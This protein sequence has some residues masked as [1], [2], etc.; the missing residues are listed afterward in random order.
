[1]S[2]QAQI[3]EAGRRRRAWLAPLLLLALL[4]VALYAPV[5]RGLVRQWWQEPDYGH[6]FFVPLFAGYVLWRERV[7]LQ[8]LALE[9]ANSGLL[10]MLAAV[11][12]LLAGSLGAELFVSRFS[13]L[14]LLAGMTLYLAGRKMLRAVAFPLGFLVLMIPLPA[15]LYYQLT[16]PLQLLASRA[17]EASLDLLRV[18]VVREGNLLFL[19]NYTL[20]VVEACSGVRSLLSLAALAIGYGYLLESRVWARL[21]LLLFVVPIA[22]LTNA[23]RVVATGLLTHFYGPQAADSFLHLFSGWL[24]FVVAL[25]L[26]LLVH[27]VLRRFR[28]PG[29]ETAHA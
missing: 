29:G 21:A 20:E 9:P 5:L 17:A 24:T 6:G 8:K 15:I 25:G 16:F 3:W 13:L 10:V 23:L 26:L 1:M 18:P 12:L 11:G 7:R 2:V 28:L 22:V 4:G 27:S 14:L 19:P